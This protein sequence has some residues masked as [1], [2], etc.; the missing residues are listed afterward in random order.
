M[1]SAF[2]DWSVLTILFCVYASGAFAARLR[3]APKLFMAMVLFTFTWAL[4][5]LYWS[6]SE[7]TTKD[8][9]GVYTS[10]L[11]IC[12]ASL[13]A[14]YDEEV[15][16][17]AKWSYLEVLQSVVQYGSIPLLYFVATGQAFSVF[18]RSQV[19]ALVELGLGIIGFSAIA[20]TGWKLLGP[21]A[22]VTLI[23][24]VFLP[25]IAIGTA[26]AMQKFP[27]FFDPAYTSFMP[28]YFEP[29]AIVLKLLYT[30][31]FGTFIAFVGMDEDRRGMGIWPLVNKIFHL[32]A[33][34]V[35][36]PGASKREVIE[37]AA[38]MREH[39]ATKDDVAE[40]LK[41]SR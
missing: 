5:V 16:G 41:R 22:S 35:P 9:I 38:F 8:S 17:R 24:L 26:D 27:T 36:V 34:P 4:A 33:P 18:D 32:P 31:L 21:R 13:L 10:F 39:A 19:A 20:L 25:Y 3:D 2:S 15:R 14:A 23:L 40:I 37:L 6:T 30:G 11:S 29:A 12:I 28:A 7:S 1:K